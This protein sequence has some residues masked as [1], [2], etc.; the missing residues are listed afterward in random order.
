MIEI[1]D[2]NS[3]AQLENTITS[4]DVVVVLFHAPAW[5]APCRKLHPHVEEASNRTDATFVQVDVD[6]N[7]E[8]ASKYNIM[9]VPVLQLYRAGE[10][11][12]NLE[13][14]TV[15]PLLSEINS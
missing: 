14:R 12:K 4:N 5:C 8:V 3:L 1:I 6:L 9:S 13:A 15:L 7:P 11:E 10:F 2:I